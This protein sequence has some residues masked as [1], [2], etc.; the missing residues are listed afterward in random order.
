M[1]TADTAPRIWVTLLLDG[2]QRES[3]SLEVTHPLLDDLRAV[4]AGERSHAIFQIPLREGAA[5][6]TLPAH[7][8][9]GVITEPPVPLTLPATGAPAATPARMQVPAP[10]MADGIHEVR[11]VQIENVLTARQHQE[12]LAFVASREKDF[13]ATSMIDGL[14]NHR[15]STVIYDFEPFAALIRS[16]IAHLL[17]KACEMLGL[18]VPAGAVDAQLTAH[19]DNNFYRMHNDN[20]AGPAVTRVLTFVYYFNRQPRAYS[21]GELRIYDREVKDGLR[22]AADS[23]KTIEPVDNSMVFFDAGDYHEVMPVHCQTLN[24]LD[25]RFTINGW[26]NRSVNEPALAAA[27]DVV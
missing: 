3:L 22:Y 27:G 4:L 13:V 12:L 8:I 25:S 18:Q 6:L 2:G 11:A 26:V 21:G 5:L 10:G 20:A 7:R 19:N 16:R 14:P 9:I 17:P 15:A 23:Y 24:F 1:S